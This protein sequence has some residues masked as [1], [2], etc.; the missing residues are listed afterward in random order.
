MSSRLLR[1]ADSLLF[2]IGRHNV[3]LITG[4]LEKQN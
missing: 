1:I 2:P 4:I 3:W